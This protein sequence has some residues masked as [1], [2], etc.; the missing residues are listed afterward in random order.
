MSGGLRL[1]RVRGIDIVADWS[2]LLIVA[3]IVMGLSHAF[4]RWHPDWDAT[5]RWVT[6]VAA[7]L[8]FLLSIVVHELS[9]AVVGRAQGMRIDRIT[10]FVFGGMAHLEEEPPGWKAEFWM[11]IVGP[12]VSAAIGIGLLL[13]VGPG[14]DPELAARD[15]QRA[16]GALG[17]VAS[18]ALWV[19]W[20]NLLLAGFN[21]IPGY[22]LDGGRVLRALLWKATGSLR[23]ATVMSATLGR[24][25]AWLLMGAGVAMMLGVQVP[26]LGTGLVGG[27]WA[28]LIGWFLHNAA[29]AGMRQTV[30]RERL[31]G[32]PLGRVM[33]AGGAAVAPD[34][35]LEALVEEHLLGR[36]QRA[37]P[38]VDADGRLIGLV[39]LTDVRRVDREQ[40]RRTRVDAVMTP[41]DKLAVL[42][43]DDDLGAAAEQLARLG[44]NQIPV[45]SAGRVEGMVSREDILRWMMLFGDEDGSGSRPAG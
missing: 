45:L 2:V 16:Y 9:H 23:R 8:V 35:S 43:V 31:R 29:L 14:I 39:S 25:F 26:V 37:C 3:V 41:R 24:T 28:A 19:G 6:A 5:T 1:A 30:L 33:R 27:V 4:G 40:W 18:L 20:V 15:P 34:V 7:S 13:A 11:A 12:L 38:V 22:P 17:P 44:I 32:V 21:L 36:G 42:A 10:L